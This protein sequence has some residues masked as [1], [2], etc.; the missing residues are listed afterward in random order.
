MQSRS[1]ARAVE[2]VAVE[3]VH[4]V[5]RRQSW[6]RLVVHSVETLVLGVSSNVKTRS[7][8]NILKVIFVMCLNDDSTLGSLEGLIFLLSKCRNQG[9]YQIKYLCSN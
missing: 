3:V 2:A 1:D 5:R 4:A 7:G 6:Y 8:T 9:Q